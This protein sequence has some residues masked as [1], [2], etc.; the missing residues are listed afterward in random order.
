LSEG[1]GRIRTE[2]L[3]DFHAQQALE[4]RQI[5]VHAWEPFSERSSGLNLRF[6]ALS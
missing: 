6:R 5:K 3:F 2:D 1:L 4:A